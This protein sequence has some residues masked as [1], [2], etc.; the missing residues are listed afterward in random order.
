MNSESGTN[1]CLSEFFK[2]LYFTQIFKAFRIAINPSRLFI[3]FLGVILLIASGYLLQHLEKGVNIINKSEA[4]KFHP[5]VAEITEGRSPITE[6]DVYLN[7]PH[8]LH[9]FRNAEFSRQIGVFRALGWKI[10][11]SINYITLESVKLNALGI[12]TELG[13]LA[14]TIFWSIKFYPLFAIPYYLISV[15]VLAFFGGAVCRSAAIEHCSGTKT[16]PGAGLRFASEKVW[17]LL[18]APLAPIVLMIFLGFIIFIAGAAGRLPAV[19]DF[20]FGF[21]AVFGL[22]IGFVITLILIGFLAGVHM[23]AP[24]ITI[25]NSDFNEAVNRSY[26][27]AYTKPWYLLFYS[28]I[29]VFYGAVCYMFVRLCAYLMLRIT[30]AFFEVS[31]ISGDWGLREHWAR[32]VFFNLSGTMGNGTNFGSEHLLLNIAIL[33]I[34]SVIASFMVSFYYC[35]S[36]IIYTLLRKKADGV[37]IEKIFL[38]SESRKHTLAKENNQSG[39]EES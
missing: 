28:L 23:M 27:Y 2:N 29:S 35:C 24:T 12:F 1:R 6:I 18:C 10:S 17:D 16:G 37:P 25:E 38:F 7:K 22:I 21:C 34:I 3:A 5:E 4:E 39:Q 31:A 20:I 11:G 14:K 30:Y 8:E 32:P 13:N 36:T 15:C 19:G 26:G 9:K 33:L